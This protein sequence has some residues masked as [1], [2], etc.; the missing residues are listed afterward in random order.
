MSMLH[1]VQNYLTQ[2]GGYE[3]RGI[4]QKDV[5]ARSRTELWIRQFLVL[6]LGD[7]LV[8]EAPTTLWR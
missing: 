5:T 2:P 4:A 6:I 8:G 1:K 7:R 3:V